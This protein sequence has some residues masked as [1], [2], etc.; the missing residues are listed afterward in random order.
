MASAEICTK[1]LFFAPVSIIMSYTENFQG[2][3]LDVQAVNVPTGVSIQHRIQE[4][5]TRM[6][7]HYAGITHA[8]IYLEDK[9]EKSVQAKSVRIRLG[10]PGKDAFASDTGDSFMALLSSVEDKLLR[11]LDK[12]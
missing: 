10:I 1:S 4:L 2:I 7:K 11:Q 3:K 8:D 6:Q 9:P 5:L 12:K